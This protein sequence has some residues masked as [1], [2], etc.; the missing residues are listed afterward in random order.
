MAVAG[1]VVKDIARPSPLHFDSIVLR[2]TSLLN[3]QDGSQEPEVEI[4][5]PVLHLVFKT[6]TPVCVVGLY[7]LEPKNLFHFQDVSFHTC[8]V[9]LE[10]DIMLQ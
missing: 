5:L 9:K 10:V 3:I 7:C 4:T 1:K 8:C 2:L 6:M